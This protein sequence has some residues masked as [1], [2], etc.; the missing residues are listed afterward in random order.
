MVWCTVYRPT[1]IYMSLFLN[2]FWLAKCWGWG[3][4]P[5]CPPPPC[6]YGHVSTFETESISL[7]KSCCKNDAN[8]YI[9]SAISN[10]ALV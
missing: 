2:S 6:S 7:N 5:P 10:N 3:Q 1:L 8:M 9:T 4:L